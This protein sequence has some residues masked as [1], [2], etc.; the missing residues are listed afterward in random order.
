[1]NV[2]SA[3]MR[4][5]FQWV[6]GSVGLSLRM[7]FVDSLIWFIGVQAVGR[8]YNTERLAIVSPWIRQNTSGIS[9]L[10]R[11]KETYIYSYIWKQA[12]S[13]CHSWLVHLGM[14]YFQCWL[15]ELRALRGH[16]VTGS[17]M[18]YNTNL[19]FYYGRSSKETNSP[20]SNT[21]SGQPY[22]VIKHLTKWH[23]FWT[24]YF[25]LIMYQ[26]LEHNTKEGNQ[27]FDRAAMS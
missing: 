21:Y 12:S 20:C 8:G 4:L 26:R 23:S 18:Y 6:T 17:I 1:M 7:T 11:W 15:I 13:F 25:M 14:W 2:K 19:P 16:N 24:E 22:S 10:N 5:T 3:V 9:A 27:L